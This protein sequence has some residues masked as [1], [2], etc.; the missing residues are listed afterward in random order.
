MHA[1][2]H[3]FSL[4]LSLARS[5]SH[6]HTHTHA[7][8]HTPT[9]TSAHTYTHTKKSVHKHTHPR[10]QFLSFFFHV[11]LYEHPT[12]R[13]RFVG[14]RESQVSSRKRATNYRALFGK[15]PA[16]LRHSA[17]FRHSVHSIVIP[18]CECDYMLVALLQKETCHG[19]CVIMYTLW[20][21]DWWCFYYFVILSLAL[22]EASFS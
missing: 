14:S 13:R 3:K 8:T 7:H 5:L 2:R 12:G 16:N 15:W 11:E 4:S 17:H 20:S 21:I 9:H 22:L 10:A 1:T 19:L 18:Y 6:S